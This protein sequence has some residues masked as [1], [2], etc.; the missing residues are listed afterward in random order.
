MLQYISNNGK[1]YEERY[2]EA[3]TQIPLYTDEW[4]DFNPADPGI[5]ILETLIGFETLQQEHILDAS[6]E[7]KRRLLSLVGFTPERGK[8]AR[9]LLAADQVTAPMTLP[10]NHKF[11][12]GDMFFETDRQIEIS[13]RRLV[14]IFGKKVDEEE[15][16]NFDFLSDRE[17]TVP[18]SI[19]GEKPVAGDELYLIA[20]ELPPAGTETIFYFRLRERYNRNPMG[21]HTENAFASIRWECY[22]DDGWEEMRVRDATNAFLMSGEVR[23]WIPENAAVCSDAPV[24]GYCI[25]AVLTF[26]EYDVRPRLTG[27]EAFLFEVWQKH[28]VSECM[29]YGKATEINVVSG[30]GEEVYVNVFVRE[31]KG[32]SYRA[33]DYSPDPERQGRY[34][35]RIDNGIGNYTIRFDRSKR[36]FAPERSRDC[37]RVVLYT[38]EVMR[39]Y[40][41]GKVLG[42]DNQRL[43]LPYERIVPHNFCIIARR[44]D[45]DGEPYYD[46]VR[47]EHDSD[48]GLYYHLYE[49]DGE[50]EIEDAGDF[51]GAELFLAGIATH[52][53]ESGN[54][55][56][57]NYL[58]SIGDNSGNTYY[59]PGEGTGGAYRETLEDVRN[60]FLRDMDMAYTA[61]TTADYEAIVKTTPGLCIHKAHARMD[62]TKNLVSVAVKPGTDDEFPK[63]PELYRT[64]I[65]K[66][67]EQRRLLTTRIELEQPVYTAV[68]VSGTV[69]VK[70]HYE[71]CREE[72]ENT[73]K[74][75]IDYLNSEKNFGERLHFDEVFHAIE[76]LDG[77]EFVYDL[78]IRPKSLAAAKMEDAD[79][80]PAFNCLLY[81]GQIHIETVTA[82]D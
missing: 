13:D 23:M 8:R 82:T 66:R 78:S 54:I 69:Y 14:G 18:A 4:T 15:F 75:H 65:M 71:N 35:D 55:R 22:T 11:Q 38:E 24:E 56:A 9:L 72:I 31:A 40:R 33:Y 36:G 70:L 60:R 45:S 50:I 34:Y 21:K 1:S 10:S 3:I 6:P 68:N 51:I 26:S 7:V 74:Q 81:P 42:F 67:L 44:L 19:F 46:F 43:T 17:V 62:E 12:I 52:E 2:E 58:T 27:I 39:Q 76:M 48:G 37:V 25:R 5:T 73:V 30:M 57:G 80:I 20:N 29:S 63:L 79:I 41:I 28:T 16:K 47:P 32:A 53:G 64:V 49:G 59:N 61:V 77:V